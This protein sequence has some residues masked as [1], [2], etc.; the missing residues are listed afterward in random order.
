MKTPRKRLE[1]TLKESSKRLK[2][3]PKWARS[4]LSSPFNPKP[5]K[6]A[7]KTTK[8]TTKKAKI[9][10]GFMPI[11]GTNKRYAISKTGSI[12][13]VRTGMFIRP[14]DFDHWS[15]RVSLYL[16]N[17]RRITRNIETLVRNTY[18]NLPGNF[19]ATRMKVKTTHR[20]LKNKMT[21]RIVTRA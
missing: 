14:K 4:A 20:N 12:Y 21:A 19:R 10:Q 18:R 1:E 11:P 3:L 15:G 9:R 5:T 6:K 17:K 13:N 16:G 7:M 8:K 2:E